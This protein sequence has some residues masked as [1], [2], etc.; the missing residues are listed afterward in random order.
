MRFNFACVVALLCGTL[1]RAADAPSPTTRPS[2][3]TYQRLA[4]ETEANLKRDIL[5]KWFPAAD[6]AQYGGFLENF[7][8]DWSRGAGG[9][10][11][12][13]Y[14]SRLTWLSA[15]AALRFPGQAEKC[16]AETRRGA[17]FLADKMWD[18]E[19]GGFY[20]STDDAGRPARQGANQKHV[21]GIAFAMDALAASHQATHDAAALDL[22]KQTFRWLEEHAHDGKNGGYIEALTLDGKPIDA[23]TRGNDAIGTRF[24]LKSMNTHIHVLE[25]LTGL[26]AVWKDPAVRSRLEEVFGIV[27]D[28]V[29][30]DPGRLHMFFNAN[31]TPVPGRD[32][33]GHDIETAFLLAEA[34]EA[35]GKADDATTWSR[36]RRLVDHAL[37]VGFDHE[38]GGF[39][40]EG[41]V[42]GENLRKDKVWWVEA[43]GLNAL[44]LMH[45]RFGRETPRYWE[46]FVKQWDFISR[47]Q[48]DHTHGGWYPTVRPDGTPQPGRAKSDG[49]TEGYH[50]GRAMLTVS[51][52]L[53]R[54]AEPK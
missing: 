10:K 53:R 1:C 50:Q 5:D 26:Y 43:E 24:G 2:P 32:S 22:A 38:H 19:R 15:Q 47:Y 46:A 49:W 8:E 9:Q 42:T 45:E 27:R 39:Y 31:W 44:L 51:A 21:Y 33:F 36:A 52:A 17:A 30:A 7:R 23:T 3:E 25:A 13:V 29:Y 20:W 41:T 40:D 11:S 4:A 18:K 6:D 35:L 28:K 37:E 54:L 34:A 16:L 14:Q 12:I 48:V